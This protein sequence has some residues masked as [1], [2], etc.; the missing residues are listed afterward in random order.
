MITASIL[1]A[2]CSVVLP[3][4]MLLLLLISSS[5][6]IPLLLP[7]WRRHHSPHVDDDPRVP[8]RSIITTTAAAPTVRILLVLAIFVAALLVAP[9]YSSPYRTFSLEALG[10]ASFAYV[11]SCESQSSIPKQEEDEQ[12]E[13]ETNHGENSSNDDDSWSRTTVSTDAEDAFADVLLELKD[14][15]RTTTTTR[16]NTRRGRSVV[17]HP[18]II[19]PEATSTARLLLDPS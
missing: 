13:V 18:S 9:R 15:W 19:A 4:I 16:R 6:R 12:E 5:A 10:W 1:E 3:A 17:R 2:A 7:G 8:S 14:R 11:S